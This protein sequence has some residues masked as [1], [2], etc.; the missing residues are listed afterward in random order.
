M[1]I[2]G[3]NEKKS[4]T[5]IGNEMDIAVNELKNLGIGE[6]FIQSGNQTATKIK[7]P[8]TLLKNNNAM[9]KVMWKKL[10]AENLKN[11]M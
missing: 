5:A 8:K 3:K 2:A 6:F 11:I 1:K 9:S 7:A 4:L 10:K